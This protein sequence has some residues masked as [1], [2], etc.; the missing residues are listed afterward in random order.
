MLLYQAEPLVGDNRLAIPLPYFVLEYLPGFKQLSL[1]FRLF[2]GCNWP[3]SWLWPANASQ[4]WRIILT[5]VLCENVGHAYIIGIPEVSAL[6]SGEAAK[7][8]LDAP[9]GGV[10]IYPHAA[11]PHLYCSASIENPWQPVLITGKWGI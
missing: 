2:L 6:P 5:F 8:L 7:Q 10:A 1:L 3:W 4:Q 11:R 9:D